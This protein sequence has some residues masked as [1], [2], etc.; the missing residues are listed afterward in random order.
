MRGV[1]ATT[2]SILAVGLLAGSAVGVAAQDDAADP[3]APST[4]AWRLGDEEA[5]Q[6]YFIE[7]VDPR[8]SGQM[9]LSDLPS[10]ETDAN[11]VAS[12]EG[13]LVNDGGAWVGIGREVGGG[14]TDLTGGDWQEG[15]HDTFW[16]A[17]VAIWEMTGE[18]GYEG[19]SLILVD[20][21]PETSLG[22]WGII[23]PSEPP[24]DP[25]MVT[26]KSQR[27]ASAARG[28]HRCAG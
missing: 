8:A 21:F 14:T 20:H 10:I 11:W 4:F 22:P 12:Y 27:V 7:A 15:E 13:R 23:Y 16:E 18:E 17:G 25:T 2:I 6:G 3:M 9:T 26:S 19:L 1:K 24:V 5:E 28:A